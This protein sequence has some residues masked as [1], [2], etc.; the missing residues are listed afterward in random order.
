MS[1]IRDP[2]L[3]SLAQQLRER[4]RIADLLE[5]RGV[6]VSR[7]SNGTAWALCPIHAEHTPS[8]QITQRNG[9]ERFRCWGCGAHGDVFDFV[10]LLGNHPDYLTTLRALAQEHGLPFPE[11]Q[12]AAPRHDVQVLELAAAH[13]AR[14]L[15]PDVL[16]YLDERGFP[17][18]FVRSAGIGYASTDNRAGLARACEAKGLVDAATALGLL[19]PE[20]QGRG[21]REHFGS[22]A[23]GYI[24]FPNRQNNHVVDLQGRAFP[25]K[26]GTPKYLNLTGAHRGFYNE[27]A[28]AHG[29]VL[30]CEGIPDTL[31]VL[32]A[33]L[34]AAGLYG[35]HGWG[36]A[37]RSKFRR[38]ERVYVALDRDATER[39]I[40]IGREFGTR[41]RVL[42][43]PDALGPKGDL[44]D[45]LCGPAKRDPAVFKS[46]LEAAMPKA[47]TPWAVWISRLPQ[48]TPLWNLE[49]VLTPLLAE[50]AH[51][52]PLIRDAHL[53][54]LSERVGL[55]WRTLVDACREPADA[56]GPE[57]SE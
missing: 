30:L 21:V 2:G 52:H 36:S 35:K 20:P 19:L 38:C 41:S 53:L 18:S 34:P 29:H 16:H 24:I 26:T 28:L 22:R 43:P 55:P 44:N 51:Q 15:T 49:D 56:A 57:E 50:L 8:F 7:R 48:E 47:P 9:I 17:E 1:M 42:I 31:S 11:R 32:R 23:T 27:A 14:S 37:Y 12:P 33:G 10:Q 54:L 4:I 5:Q 46:L 39:A 45:W 6:R 40:A 3:S 13:Y 25:A